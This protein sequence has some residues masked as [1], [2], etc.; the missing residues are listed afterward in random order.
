MG[1]DMSTTL[2]VSGKVTADLPLLKF[3]MIGFGSN[4]R[5]QIIDAVRV[6]PQST[7]IWRDSAFSSA[8]CWLVCGEKTR[9]VPSSAGL[10]NTTLRVLAGLPTEYARTLTLSD[11]DRPLAFSIPLH[12]NHI[13]SQLTFDPSSPQD[14]HG[15][16]TQ[17]QERMRPTLARFVLGRELIRRGTGLEEAVY[18][19]MHSGN[20]LAILDFTAWRMGLSPA[21]NLQHLENAV[22][23][24]RPTQARAIPAHFLPTDVEQLRWTYA[25]FTTQDVLPA[26]YKNGLIYFRQS[27]CVPLSWLTDSHLLLLQELSMQ[28]AD[29]LTLVKRTGLAP[30]QLIR[31]L[32]SLYFAASL[33]TKAGQ[34]AHA[35][36]DKATPN[37]VNPS[38]FGEN[39]SGTS[40]S[41]MSA[42]ERKFP[43]HAETVPAQL[44]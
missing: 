17:F 24:K 39:F 4:A 31:D 18:H 8:D 28:P 42:N 41:S 19:V 3:G 44:R 15:V 20:L 26:R 40:D 5:Q 12:G 38:K 1:A 10:Q 22:W 29:L 25:Q 30:E 27:P 11:I 2:T 36:S 35:N 33:T 34:A 7:V 21:V 23:H 9:P 43:N 13:A 6:M 14:I 37:N 32:T 16:L